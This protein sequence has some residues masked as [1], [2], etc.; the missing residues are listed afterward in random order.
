ME[1]P[2]VDSLL[3]LS[4]YVLNIK[5]I[6]VLYDIGGECE[7]GAAECQERNGKMRRRIMI[8]EFLSCF[9]RRL[10]RRRVVCT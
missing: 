7:Q 5:L 1:I 6:H 4:S 2:I 8:S 9:C 3:A 10:R